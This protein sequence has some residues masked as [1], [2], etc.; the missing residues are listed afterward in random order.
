MGIVRTVLGDVEACELGTT[1]MHEHIICSIS[2]EQTITEDD[3]AQ[4]LRAYLDC[5]GRSIVELTNTGMGQR[6]QALEQLARATGVII[7]AG[8]GF[9]VEK[10]HPPL[11]S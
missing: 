4:D 5:G 6:A 2:N 8:T 3:V 1:L 9:Y 7:V 11:V 10:W